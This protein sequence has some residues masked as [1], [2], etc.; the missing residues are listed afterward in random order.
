MSIGAIVGETGAVVKDDS[1]KKYRACDL[2][3]VYISECQ[4][5]LQGHEKCAKEQGS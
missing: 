2:M 5:S 4:I 3:S 1:R